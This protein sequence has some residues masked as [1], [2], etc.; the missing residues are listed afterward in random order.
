MY[1]MNFIELKYC[2]YYNM[3]EGKNKY[4]FVNLI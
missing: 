1:R 2:I 3:D 4:L